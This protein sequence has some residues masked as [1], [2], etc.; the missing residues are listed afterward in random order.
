MLQRGGKPFFLSLGNQLK[1]WSMEFDYHHCL[2]V[3][4]QGLGSLRRASQ[5]I[6]FAPQPLKE[7]NSHAC[8]RKTSPPSRL[9]LHPGSEI[10]LQLLGETLEPII[11]NTTNSHLEDP[12]WVFSP[13][14]HLESLFHYWMTVTNGKTIFTYGWNLLYFC[15]I[16]YLLPQPTH[17]FHVVFLWP[18]STYHTSAHKL[19][20]F[21]FHISHCDLPLWFSLII[22]LFLWWW[23]LLFCVWGN[24]SQTV[25]AWEEAVCKMLSEGMRKREMIPALHLCTWLWTSQEQES[26]ENMQHAQFPWGKRVCILV[27]VWAAKHLI[28][29]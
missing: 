12:K 13:S 19:P 15:Q 25:R 11:L 7:V 2:S 16:S 27:A 14:L 1:L 26:Q 17:P 10:L 23:L 18:S 20:L 5:E 4:L 29:D 8:P 21:Y 28:W 9:H 3:V 24:F 6:L 22:S